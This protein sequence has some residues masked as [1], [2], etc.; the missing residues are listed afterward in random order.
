MPT[1]TA[2]TTKTFNAPGATITYD[3]YPSESPAT[4]T[5]LVILG[6]PMAASGF[7]T[8]ASHF[9]DRTVVTYDPRGTE[10]SPKAD[11]ATESDPRQHADDIHRVIDAVG[12][13]P[14]DLFATSGGAINA[15]ALMELHPE[16]V[17]TL[18]AHEPPA[19]A[20]LPDAPA[21]LAAAEDIGATYQRAGFGPA[22]AKFIILVSHSGEIPPG[23]FAG[24][25]PDPAMF[26]LPAQDD[27]T[28]T[29]PLL[30][31]NIRTCTHYAFDVESLRAAKDLIVFAVGEDSA[32]QMA[33][34]G[35]EAIAALLGA[36]PI[37]FPGGHAGFL[38]DEYGPGQG[39]K[40]AEFAAKLRE[41]LAGDF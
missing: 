32:G 13:G 9:P 15:L 33:R 37:I 20:M 39:G 8:L 36:E 31:Q 2:P 4:E 26:H 18:V 21:A 23:L 27:G 28:R 24:P 29:D 38:G 1:T 35:G 40:P 34:R 16:D 3:V 11:P 25:D 10:R 17:R 7:R 19:A 22:M 6:S 12:G 5:P 30:F 41:V 14:V